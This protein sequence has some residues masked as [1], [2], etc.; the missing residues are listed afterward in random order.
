MQ[1]SFGNLISNDPLV[2]AVFDA[3]VR[4]T[5][6]PFEKLHAISRAGRI[7]E[8]YLGQNITSATREIIAQT[9]EGSSGLSPFFPS[10]PQLADSFQSQTVTNQPPS[11]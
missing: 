4:T 6:A 5:A 2:S 11:A 7:A 10:E 8:A 3:V 9:L 1:P